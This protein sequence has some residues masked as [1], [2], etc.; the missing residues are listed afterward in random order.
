MYECRRCGK[1]ASL[2]LKNIQYWDTQKL[3]E[4]K[5]TRFFEKLLCYVTKK[6]IQDSMTLLYGY[7]QENEWKTCITT[8]RLQR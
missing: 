7:P 5:I 8:A 1:A 4:K 6:N 3:N 2:F